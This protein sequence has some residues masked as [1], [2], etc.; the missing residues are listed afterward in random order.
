MATNKNSKQVDPSVSTSASKYLSC[1]YQ[2]YGLEKA[3][4]RYKC[5]YCVLI[6]K[7]PIQLTECGH[8]TCKGC[9]ESRATDTADDMMLCPVVDCD[10]K[11][12]KNQVKIILMFIR[13]YIFI[14]FKDND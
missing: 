13:S 7:E 4:N 8:R 12:H 3:D 6:M 1:G 9:F 11:F 2:I 10:T 14:H 5:P